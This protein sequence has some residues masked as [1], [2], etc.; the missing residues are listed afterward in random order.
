MSPLRQLQH[1]RVARAGT[2]REDGRLM[3]YAS[4]GGRQKWQKNGA[5]HS[6]EWS[7]RITPARSGCGQKT[8][9]KSTAT[10]SRTRF[11]AHAR[12]PT[13]S[14]RNTMF[15]PRR[16][17]SSMAS[18]SAAATNS[19]AF[20]RR[21][22]AGRFRNRRALP[23]TQVLE[24]GPI[25]KLAEREGFEPSIRGYRIHTFQACAFDRSATAPHAFR[26]GG[27]P[28]GAGA[29]LQA[30]RLAPCAAHAYP[31]FHDPH[32]WNASFGRRDGTDGSR[33]T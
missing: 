18:G 30:A 21:V 20:W 33:C 7:F 8:C 26:Q 24:H 4:S 2:S 23:V 27:A 22:E 25:G 19:P 9:W 15:R 1:Q 13:L 3:F 17:S 5:R 10:K 32:D 31:D 14:R 29:G 11:S 16:R 28:S 6:I 12:K